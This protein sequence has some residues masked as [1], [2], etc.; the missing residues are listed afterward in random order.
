[1]APG[2]GTPE[3]VP[4]AQLVAARGPR[5]VAAG[6]PGAVALSVAAVALAS[7]LAG[8][9][10]T[11]GQ[12]P[13]RLLNCPLRALTG[14]PCPG[15]GTTH[16]LLAL[17]H[18]EVR[19]ALWASPL[20]ALGLLLLWAFGLFT[21]LRLAG[22]RQTVWLPAPSSTAQRTL[23]RAALLSLGANWAFVALVSHGGAQ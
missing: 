2:P 9:L 19:A 16:A 17:G 3:A 5:W 14:I 7:A 12:G 4:L 23:R 11:P 20:A 8:R 22:L 13:L 18:G 21:L 6:P 15:C 10:L 1:M